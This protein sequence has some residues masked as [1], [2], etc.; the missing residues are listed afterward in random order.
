MLQEDD[1]S[2]SNLTKIRTST[3]A[4]LKGA[5]KDSGDSDT[6]KKTFDTNSHI[7]NLIDRIK[8]EIWS[9]L[10]AINTL[11]M[12]VILLIP[13]IEDGNNFGVEVQEE[14]LGE[15]KAI[16]QELAGNEEQIVAELRNSCSSVYDLVEKNRDKITTP[17]G[18]SGM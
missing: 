5:Q 3:A 14:T 7:V 11:R 9:L 18:E 13:K 15:L 4:T 12:W 1:F 2:L 8:P 10:D 16:E 6:E 17:R